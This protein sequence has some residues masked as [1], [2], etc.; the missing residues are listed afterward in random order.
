MYEYYLQ[1][2][3]RIVPNVATDPWADYMANDLQQSRVRSR[4]VAPIVQGLGT[5]TQQVWGLLMVHAYSHRRQWQASEANLLQRLGNQLAIAI[6]QASL[7]QQL[8][9]QLAERQ[10]AEAAVRASEELFRRAFDDAP[11]G[12]SLVSPE[13]QFLRVNRY[14]CD[15][16]EFSPGEL[17]QMNFSEITHPED[18][19]A[20]LDGFEQMRRGDLQTWQ[21]EKRYITKSGT[22]VPVILNAS[23]VRDLEGEPLY[24]IGHIQDIRARLEVDRIKDEFVSIVSH[25]LRTPITSIAGSLMLLGADVYKNRPEKARNMLDIAI[26]NS[27][28]LV[29]LVDDILSFERFESGQVELTKEPCLVQDL[30]L[31]AKDSVHSLAD[32]AAVRLSVEP[33]EATLHAAP[34]AMVQTLTNLLSNAIKYSNPGQTVWLAA[35]EWKGE[36]GSQGAEE[37]GQVSGIRYQVSGAGYQVSGTPTHP[38]Y[39]SESHLRV[40]HP[41]I[42][43]STHLPT[44]LPTPSILFSVKDQGRGIPPEKLERIFEQFQQVDVSDARQKGGTGLGLAICKRIVQQHGG[45]IWV[46]SQLGR[47]STFYFTVPMGEES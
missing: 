38:P 26:K 18:L 33:L 30:M 11:I 13:G 17:L 29:R 28:R 34:D 3:A 14:Y 6:D 32:C 24:C 40:Y 9:Q 41:P 16:L 45:A 25:E 12:I 15:L 19:G 23:L 46:E 20:D 7:F 43:L 47:G 39:P 36:R 35:R 5:E 10:Q 44:H 37:R 4:I 31:Q 27:N 21:M 22:V 1:G 42:H 2:K 8:Q